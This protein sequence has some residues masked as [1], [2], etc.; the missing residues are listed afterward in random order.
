M[1]N[2]LITVQ[3][4]PEGSLWQDPPRYW[5]DIVWPAY[6]K[7][8]KNIF[9]GGDVSYGDAVVV[10]EGHSVEPPTVERLSAI[11]GTGSGKGEKDGEPGAN[12]LNST[13]QPG[14]GEDERGH[15]GSPAVCGRPVPRLHLLPAETMDM[16]E[17]FETACAALQ[18]AV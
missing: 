13:S 11:K 12:G 15:T 4:S 2:P 1:L 6:L 14:E 8:H 7:A 10:G 16:E 18:D 9:V 17:L 3:F 5:D